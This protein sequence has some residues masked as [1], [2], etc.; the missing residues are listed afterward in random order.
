MGILRVEHHSVAELLSGIRR[1][2]LLGRPDALPYADSDTELCLLDT[3]E[4]V[5]TQRCVMT[6][7]IAMV[8]NLH[9]ALRDRGFDLFRLEGYLTIWLEDRND[10]IDVLPPVV[11]QSPEADGSVVKILSDGMHRA[12]LARM[13]RSRV[14]VVYIRNVPE[15]YPYHAFPLVNGWADVEIR[16]DL[17]DGYIKEWHRVRDYNS[18]RR[19]SGSAFLNCSETEGMLPG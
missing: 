11:E 3:D 9:W 5:P 1:V 15:A 7:Q 14:Q 16:Q 17:P 12:Y 2:A 4:I 13:E 8:Q 6:K 18:L 19:D 10:P